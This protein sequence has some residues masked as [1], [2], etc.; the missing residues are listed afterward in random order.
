MAENIL[1]ALYIKVRTTAGLCT[2]NVEQ[3]RNY[4]E[5]SREYTERAKQ[6]TGFVS[7]SPELPGQLTRAS[8]AIGELLKSIEKVDKHLGILAPLVRFQMQSKSSTNGLR[9]QTQITR[10]QR[11]RLINCSVEYRY[12]LKKFPRRLVSFRRYLNK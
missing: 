3:L 1:N 8:D 10:R 4:L 5:K 7:M 2:P 6:T 12:T 11:L 9:T